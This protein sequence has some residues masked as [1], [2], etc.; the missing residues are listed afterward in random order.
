MNS[1]ERHS[2]TRGEIE[3]ILK[4]LRFIDRARE[5][6]EE[7]GSVF[8]PV[9]AELRSSANGIYELYQGLVLPERGVT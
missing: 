1:D 7:K 9:V 3:H 5:T 6:L 4:C 8:G 2:I